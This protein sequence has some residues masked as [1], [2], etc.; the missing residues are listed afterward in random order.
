MI[1]IRRT[2]LAA[3]LLCATPLS[4]LHGQASDSAINDQ[5]KN[6]RLLPAD[7]RPAASAQL[8]AEIRSL[9]AGPNKVQLATVLASRTTEGD[10]GIAVLQAVADTLTQALAASPAPAKDDPLPRPYIE[11]AKLVRYEQ[12]TSPLPD[13]LLAKAIQMLA[14]N[15]ADIE[16]A[17]FTLKDLHGQ[18]VSLSELRGKVVLVNFWATWCLPCLL[19]MP[20]LDA[21]QTR[22]RSQGLIVLSITNDSEAAASTYFERHPYRI[23]VLLDP[24]GKTMNRFHIDGLPRSF[25]FNRDGKLVS[26]A[27]NQRSQHQFLRM[28]AQAGL[29]P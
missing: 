29:Q 24:G 4:P 21:I 11:L 10:P 9:P 7:Q 15:D 26:Q 1:T 17:G 23:S 13:P 14:A 5:L 8:A 2:L 18:M 16:S 20:D 28:L 27:M 12:V 25:V 19:E 6:L 22:F 3:I